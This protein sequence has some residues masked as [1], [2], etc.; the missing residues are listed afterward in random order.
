[1][2]TETKTLT[3]AELSELERLEREA[4]E[5]CGPTWVARDA[6]DPDG[7]DEA[8]ISVPERED[9]SGTIVSVDTIPEVARLAVAA[10]NALPALLAEI[11][12]S[13]AASRA[14]PDEGQ[15]R[16]ELGCAGHFIAA[17]HCRWHRHTQIGDYRISSVGDYYPPRGREHD[18]R[19]ETLGADPLSFFETM[20]FRTSPHPAS[21][22]EECGCRTVTDWA[23]VDAERYATAGAAQA[24]HERFVSK[25]SAL[26]RSAPPETDPGPPLRRCPEGVLG[27]MCQE[28]VDPPAPSS[29]EGGRRE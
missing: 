11:R 25:F 13:R 1:M 20:V 21:G 7:R 17:T 15:R 28:D 5:W 8:W 24:G 6:P 26:L 10:R 12:A 19:R 23:E 16:I 22:N 2:T 9:G 3:D 4:V 14:S 27:C 29:S 18:E